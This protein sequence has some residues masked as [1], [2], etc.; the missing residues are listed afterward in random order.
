MD[1]LAELISFISISLE[2]F[3]NSQVFWLPQISC[4]LLG[5][6][7]EVWRIGAFSCSSIRYCIHLFPKYIICCFSHV[8]IS[9][10]FFLICNMQTIDIVYCSSNLHWAVKFVTVM[11]PVKSVEIEKRTQRLTQDLFKTNVLS[12]FNTYDESLHI[13]S[14]KRTNLCNSKQIHRTTAENRKEGNCFLQGRF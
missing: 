1:H 2:S 10:I 5:I 9:S 4:L 6:A 12:P 11:E 14:C 7:L 3:L 13:L 8:L